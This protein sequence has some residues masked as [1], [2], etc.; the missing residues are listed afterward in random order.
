MKMDLFVDKG[1][2]LDSEN[3]VNYAQ[4]LSSGPG[5]LPSGYS[6]EGSASGHSI[7]V[8]GSAVIITKESGIEEVH[9]VKE[10][11]G[12]FMQETRISSEAKKFVLE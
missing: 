6:L 11:T 10:S 1:Y 4:V 3:K 8:T 2:K 12:A 7:Y 9:V 5:S